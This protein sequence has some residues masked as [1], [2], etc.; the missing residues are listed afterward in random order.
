MT[1]ANHEPVHAVVAMDDVLRRGLLPS[2]ELEEVMSAGGKRTG[3]A[4]SVADGRVESALESV[5]RYYLWRAKIKF[6]TQVV[7]PRIGRVDF[8]IG[9]RLILEVDGFEFHAHVD[10]F[11]NDRGRDRSAAGQGYL[12]IRVTW[13]DVM[14][15]WPRILDDLR[16][17]LR[18][19]GHRRR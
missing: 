13:W 10:S 16:A 4:L 11:R 5:V 8:L 15:N 1:V 12:T 2:H 14:H 6:R 18:R 3:M 17:V 7:L 19:R 9:E